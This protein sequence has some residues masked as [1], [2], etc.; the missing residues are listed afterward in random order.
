MAVTEAHQDTHHH[1]PGLHHQFENKAQQDE[2]Y[3]VG[4]WAFLVTEIMFFGALFMAYILYRWKYQP[5]FY[6]LHKMLDIPLG[7]T[8]TTILLFSSLAMALAVRSAQLKDRMQCFGWL[9]ITQLCAVGFCVIKTIEWSHK[10]KG[11]IVLGPNFSW[12]PPEYAA[13]IP[14]LAQISEGRAQL[15]YSLY[16]AMTGLHAIHVVVGMLLIGSLMAMWWRRDPAV[17]EDFMPTEMVG[18]YWH[19]V[20]LVWIF[21]FPLFYLIPK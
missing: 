19:F 15:F 10:F 8:N 18:L 14:E 12:P 4:M 6:A 3:A 5:E 21:L 2:C 16:F 9:G 13:K 11:G 1:E 17:T 20:D 7:A